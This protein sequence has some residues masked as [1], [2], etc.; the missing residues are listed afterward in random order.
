MKPRHHLTLALVPLLASC[1]AQEPGLSVPETVEITPVSATL[2]LVDSE[3]VGL[4]A[5]A[6]DAAGT[7]LTGRSV[8][9]RSDNPAVAAVNALGLVRPVGAGTANVTATVENVS[10]VA[11]IT[12]VPLGSHPDVAGA[13]QF[14]MGGSEI[15]A[16]Q[17]SGGGELIFSD[18]LASGDITGTVSQSGGCYRS[19]GNRSYSLS[20]DA[21]GTARMAA[22]T[23]WISF[24]AGPCSYSGT[25]QVAAPTT[26]GG[27]GHCRVP[28]SGW[29]WVTVTWSAVRQSP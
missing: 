13:W 16:G 14:V 23:G 10:A 4:S 19:Y 8:S 20:L 7:V 11:V 28:T 24:G 26:I 21:T 2:V 27:F 9:W 25:V 6:R 29:G 17:C 12:V 22:I 5:T 15:D 18:S 1:S 3:S